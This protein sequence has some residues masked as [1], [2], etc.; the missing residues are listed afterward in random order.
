MSAR[1]ALTAEAGPIAVAVNPT[2]GR[3]RG[4]RVG[5]SVLKLLKDRGFDARAL[6][7]H[8]AAE[9]QA[10]L[11]DAVAKGCQ[12]LVVVGG[13]G[14]VHFGVNATAGTPIPLGIVAAGSGNDFARLL[15]L[16]VLDP[17]RAVAGL[18][19]DP[20]HA[21]DCGQVG[22]QRF[23]GVCSAGFDSAVNERGNRIRG[24]P[25]AIKYEVAML[26][27]LRSFRPV[28]LTMTVDGQTSEVEAML[29]AVGNGESYG[30][31]MRICA[32]A[33]L[34]DGL[35]HVTLLEPMSRRELLRVFPAVYRGRHIDHP[36]VRVFT[37]Q[38][39]HLSGR[40]VA[41]ADGERIGELPQE[42]RCVAGALRV[43]APP[44]T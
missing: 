37:A 36:R 17:D 22:D 31:G 16:P 20:V 15:R 23:A 35:F 33:R 21:Y 42:C 4:A 11:A 29:I 14:M 39:V 25:A 28:A 38:Q 43:I 19:G 3:G 30:G 44:L 13:D 9:L 7:G 5:L 12:A 6:V 1:A 41:Y 2:S 34:D 10:Q 18:V 40:A 27:E 8:D 24:I 32:G 26:A